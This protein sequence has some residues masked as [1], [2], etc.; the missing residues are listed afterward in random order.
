MLL[1]RE[2][3]AAPAPQGLTVRYSKN[4]TL[5]KNWMI[6]PWL[7]FA[8]C[9]IDGFAAR[10]VP[11]IGDVLPLQRLRS[12][13]CEGIVHP[14]SR[15]GNLIPVWWFY[16]LSPEKA[17]ARSGPTHVFPRRRTIP[18]SPTPDIQ[19]ENPLSQRFT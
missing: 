18:R 19:S 12:Q 4:T 16:R 13:F 17:R 8:M 15:E 5:L 9:Q 11:T 6:A 14:G 10:I 2:V 7:H 1:E 3:I